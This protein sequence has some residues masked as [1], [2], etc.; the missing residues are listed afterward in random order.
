MKFLR[1]IASNLRRNRLRNALTMASVMVALFL[2]GMLRSVL[3]TLDAAVDVGSESRLVTRNAISLI[4]PLPMSYFER[5]RAMPGVKS[6]SWANWFGGTYIDERNFFSKFAIDPETY[7]AMYPELQISPEERAAFMAERNAALVGPK[8]IERYKWQVGQT[9][10]IQGT[11]YPGEWQFVVRGV[12]DV[13]DPSFGE[14]VLY[15][16]YDYLYEGSNRTAA[17]GTYIL[18]LSDPSRAASVAQSVDEAFKNSSAATKT[19]TERAF[20]AGF[21]GMWGNVSFLLSMVGTAVFFAILFVAANTM[22]MAARERSRELAILKTVGFPDRLLFGLVLGEA[23]LL[24][25]VGGGAGIFGVKALIGLT[26]FDGG[27]ILPGFNVEWITVVTGLGISVALGLLS[28][29]LPAWQAARLPV[30]QA[31]RRLA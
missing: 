31:L 16:H 12:Y 8:L 20:Q 22:M 25:L 13:T 6:V 30:I 11:I 26:R 4:F 24:S 2:F 9:V 21:V 10:T 1:L 15:F 29:F 27:G 23:L 28:G 5:L 14:D 3:T 18:E 17:V 19:E 7:L